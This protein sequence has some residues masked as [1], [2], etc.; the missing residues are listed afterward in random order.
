MAINPLPEIAGLRWVTEGLLR[1]PNL[2]ETD[3]Q[4]WSELRGLLPPLPAR[5]EYWTKKRC[6]IPALQYDVLANFEN[7]ELYA[8]FPYC[9]FGVG[10]P[11]LEMGRETYARRLYKATGCWRQDA[12]QAA[13]L[14]LTDEAKRDVTRNFSGTHPSFRFP[15]VWGPNFDWIP[16]HD[17]GGVAMIALQR[18]LLQWDGNRILLLPAW[19]KDWDV[20]FKLWAPGN[21]AVECVYRG[22]KVES[23]KVAPEARRQ[24][25]EDM[26]GTSA[27]P[28]SQI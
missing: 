11:N 2:P 16:D 14:G 12:I 22:G 9:H 13:L 27:A 8:V 17:H 19:P 4:A 7:P 6:L 20:S 23:L 15:A 5:V 18:M 26:S 1:L 28:S 24:D 21:T 10:K 3:R 25:L